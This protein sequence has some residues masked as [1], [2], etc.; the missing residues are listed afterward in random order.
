MARDK[1]HLY[2]ESKGVHRHVCVCVCELPVL[3][4]RTEFGSSILSLHLYYNNGY[5]DGYAKNI[6][7]SVK[8]AMTQQK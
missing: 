7:L 6:V 3:G 8:L 4:V 2:I 1:A 5:S